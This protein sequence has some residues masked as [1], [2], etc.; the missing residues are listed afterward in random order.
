MAEKTRLVN[1]NVTDFVTF[2]EKRSIF[3]RIIKNKDASVQIL[4]PTYWNSVEDFILEPCIISKWAQATTVERKTEEHIRACIEKLARIEEKDYDLGI[5]ERG[6]VSVSMERPRRGATLEKKIWRLCLKYTI[7][8][9][10]FGY[11]K[12]IETKSKI[13]IRHVFKRISEKQLKSRMCMIPDLPKEEFNNDFH[14]FVR[15]LAEEASAIEFLES[16]RGSGN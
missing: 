9:K 3:E 8:F 2:K 15:W 12:F 16:V 11:D 4:L 10:K 7:I 6:I 14:K 5:I 13:A 1:I